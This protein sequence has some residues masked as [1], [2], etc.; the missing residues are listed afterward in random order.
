MNE[1]TNDHENP[2][3]HLH[4]PRIREMETLLESL[5][6]QDRDAMPQGATARLMEAVSDA[7]AP[8][9]IA[10]D[11]AQTAQPEP[12][13]W[14]RMDGARYAAALLAAGATLAIIAARPWRSP[15]PSPSPADP[16]TSGSWSLASFER[17]LDEYLELEAADDGQLSGAVTEWEIWA[18][19]VDTEIESSMYGGDLY[20]PATDEGA[21]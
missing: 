18:Q 9:P 21:L 3:L 4:D 17:D 5:G 20:A 2:N 14:R 15:P 16:A 12:A 11:R 13:R 7:M 1:H 10:I 8:G 19:A 6:R